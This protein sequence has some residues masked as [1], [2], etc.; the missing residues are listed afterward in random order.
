MQQSLTVVGKVDVFA[1][2]EWKR[3]NRD[4]SCL[5]FF[6]KYDWCM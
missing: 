6:F 1:L 4:G 5:N 2:F 3:T